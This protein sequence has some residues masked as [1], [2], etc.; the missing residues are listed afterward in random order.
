MSA[1]DAN[2]LAERLG[3]PRF[4]PH[5]DPIP[6]EDGAVEEEPGV[7]LA[8]LERGERATVMHLEDE[9]PVVYAQLV[10]LGMWVGM[11]VRMEAR[12]DER[13]VFEGDGRRLVLAPLMAENVSVRRLEAHELPVR[14]EAA[15]TLATLQPGDSADV[16]R[17]SAACRGLERRR[18]MDLGIVAGTRVTFER[19]GLTG[20]LSAYR[21]RGAL[22][23]LREEQ[24]AMIAVANVEHAGRRVRA[25][26]N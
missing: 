11:D 26:G 9:P 5:G 23:A 10:A 6:T 2:A 8:S 16:I 21:V 13:V 17:V 24:A 25:N 12:N 14:E 22:I 18:L 20:G 1:E 3:N 4:D 15:E 19:R 7:S